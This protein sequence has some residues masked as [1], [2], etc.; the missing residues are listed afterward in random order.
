MK[1]IFLISL[2]ILTLISAGAQT[3]PDSE[4][5]DQLK[6]FNQFFM[7]LNGVYVDTL[8]VSKLTDKAITAVLSE[9]DPHSTF[10]PAD[11]MKGVQE[12]FSG[13][14]EGIGIE[15]N[16]LSDTI[17][18]VNTVVGG[19]SEL[20]GLLPN[21]RI[22]KAD[23]KDITKTKQADVP[24]ILRG[25]KGSVINLEVV[26][27]GMAEPLQFRIVR[28]KIP[29]NSLDAA[30]KV[31][32]TIGYM[33]FNRFMA[34]TMEEFDEALAAMGG[35]KSLIL[36]LRSNGGG[37]LD[38]AIAMSEK[39]LKKDDLIVYT[40]GRVAPESRAAASKDGPLSDSHVVILVDEYSA[41][42]SEIVAGALQDQ[43]RGL[44]V[45]RRTFGKGLV[46][47]QFPLSDGSAVRITIAR[48][49]T[50]SGRVI[51]KPFEMGTAGEY[52][53]D[54]MN[55]AKSGELTSDE[56]KIN[57]SLLY[58]TV[59][60]RRKV[61]GGGGIL[62]DVIVP[63]DTTTYS[64][65]WGS[66]IRMGVM[67]EFV[68]SELDKHRV[69]L[70]A[71]YPTFEAFAGYEIPDS[72]VDDLVALGDKRGVKSDPEQLDKSK[73]R[74]KMT[75][76][77]LIARTL[78]STTEYFRVVNAAEDKEFGKAIEVLRNWEKYGKE[79]VD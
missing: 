44:V 70:K 8:S 31:D 69:Q 48:Y 65:Y 54:I 25:A 3:R 21:D 60:N 7:M 45:G 22:V 47:R 16:V 76:K 66:L 17:I 59:K 34:T 11:E 9:L 28:D 79:I 30:Y 39:F 56:R 68:V 55:R 46:Q 38:Q 40:E 5:D 57:D 33:K 10:I 73:E 13:N 49:H 20:V 67:Q 78:W 29:M 27:R 63:I 26:R 32:D 75:L 41:S 23:G 42:A 14:F 64:Q 18:V 35:V 50:P 51:Q 74:I 52:R 12:S 53:M 36:D 19:P 71:D 37:Y 6:R 77:A 62:P 2:S 72:M 1:K 4:V 58:Y 15:F 24:K 61:Y 43:D